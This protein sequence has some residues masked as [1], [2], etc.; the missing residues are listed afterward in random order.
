MDYFN[1]FKPKLSIYYSRRA[2]SLSNLAISV[3][4]GS[5]ITFSWFFVRVFFYKVSF[6]I[7]MISSRYIIKSSQSISSSFCSIVWNNFDNASSSAL[8]IISYRSFKLGSFKN[9]ESMD[10]YWIGFYFYALTR[11]I[12]TVS[13]RGIV[14][15]NTTIL[16]NNATQRNLKDIMIY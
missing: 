14:E 16:R 4:D 6:I 1:F 12:F 7:P 3:L 10:L 8:W 2:I 5:L 11:G 13:E 15:L 9:I